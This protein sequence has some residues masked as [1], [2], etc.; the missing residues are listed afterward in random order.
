LLKDVDAN[1]A[2]QRNKRNFKYLADLVFTKFYKSQKRPLGKCLASAL[3]HVLTSKHGAFSR[4]RRTRDFD[5]S[6]M[7]RDVESRVER[8]ESNLASAA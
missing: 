4:P 5:G 3:L 7:S 8:G 1:I 6:N 2:N